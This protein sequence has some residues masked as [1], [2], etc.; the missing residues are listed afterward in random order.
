MKIS[1]LF[2]TSS[3][4]PIDH[5]IGL[6]SERTIQQKQKYQKSKNIKG[7][8]PGKNALDKMYSETD[9]FTQK[10]IPFIQIELDDPRN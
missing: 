8:T 6:S 9:K 3:T 1:E 5:S 7:Y 2:E 4:S 10:E